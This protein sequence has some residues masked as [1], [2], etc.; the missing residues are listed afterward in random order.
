MKTIQKRDVECLQKIIKK[1]DEVCSPARECKI[2]TAI[3]C[4][5]CPFNSKDGNCK[6]RTGMIELNKVHEGLKVRK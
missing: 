3:G 2:Y 4:Y 1:F 6:I 5:A